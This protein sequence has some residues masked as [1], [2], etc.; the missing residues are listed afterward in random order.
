MQQQKQQKSGEPTYVNEP[1]APAPAPAPPPSSSSSSSA[2]SA[3]AS[4]FLTVLVTPKLT[5]SL[6]RQPHWRVVEDIA[7][8]ELQKAFLARFPMRFDAE[9]LV[10]RSATPAL[11]L[12]GRERL[13]YRIGAEGAEEERV[14]LTVLS[15]LD[16]AY[17]ASYEKQLEQAR[18]ELLSSSMS[19]QVIADEIREGQ[20][21]AAKKWEKEVRLLK[22]HQSTNQ[23]RLFLLEQE[24]EQLQKVVSTADSRTGA[25]EQSVAGLSE[26]NSQLRTRAAA[27]E[28]QLAA[29]Q[30]VVADGVGRLTV[31][32]DGGG[33]KAASAAGTQTEGEGGEE[34]S[35]RAMQQWQQQMSGVRDWLKAGEALLRDPLG[36]KQ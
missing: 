17:K 23:K 19:F 25:L 2:A 34:A 16:S 15:E 32:P 5:F 33:E 31:Q 8:E 7:Q 30:E 20:Q 36:E 18:A 13:V 1:S 10:F 3:G 26:E 4:Q 35:R 24:K 27:L 29:L 11:G 21:A 22:E 12:D 14:L 9:R 28:A 6:P